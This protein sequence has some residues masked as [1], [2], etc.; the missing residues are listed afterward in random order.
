MKLKRIIKSTLKNF[1]PLITGEK[2]KAVKTESTSK[3]Q[4]E[5]KPRVPR[6]KLFICVDEEN[7]HLCGPWTTKEFN[8]WKKDTLNNNPDLVVIADSKYHNKKFLI[9]IWKI[10]DLEIL[11][12]I[13]LSNL[14]TSDIQNMN[15][16]FSELFNI[17]DIDVSKFNTSKVWN[18]EC[19]FDRCESVSSLDLSNFDTSMVKTMDSMFYNCQSLEK[20]DLSSF[21]T[22]QVESMSHMFSCC[23]NLTSLDLSN[24]NTKN[25][26][27]MSSMFDHCIYLN[28]INLSNF[29]ID[30]SCETTCMFEECNDLETI[31]LKNCSPVTIAR[32]KEE[33]EDFDVKLIV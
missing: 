19:M 6:K 29:N 16:F 24:F 3:K 31:I 27:D 21:N 30:P 4:Q 12:H 7:L 2:K 8:K 14:D 11:Q 28:T 13:Q 25:V 9:P 18:M 10:D 17:A 20:I 32:I 1:Y 5:R 22:S 33:I 23:T 26:R 15:S